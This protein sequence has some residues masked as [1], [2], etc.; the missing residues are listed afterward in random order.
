MKFTTTITAIVAFLPI[1]LAAPAP[2]AFDNT[3][4]NE[5]MTHENELPERKLSKN[6]GLT[7]Q[8]Y[9]SKGCAGVLFENVNVQYDAKVSQPFPYKSYKLSRSLLIGETLNVS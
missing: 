2:V 6:S 4:F 9:R 3:I 8:A 7:L 5:T 1:A